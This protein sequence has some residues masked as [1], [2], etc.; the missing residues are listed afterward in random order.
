MTSLTSC[1]RC[2]TMAAHRWPGPHRRFQKYNRDHDVQRGQRAD[3]RIPRWILRRRFR[4]DERDRLA[5]MRRHFRPEFLNRLDEI[6]VFH[7]LS[8]ENL[9]RIVEI[10]LARVRAR[11]ADRHITLELTDA[12]RLQSCPHRLRSALRRPPLKRAIQKEDRNPN[13]RLLLRGQSKTA[14]AS[15]PTHPPIPAT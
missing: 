1:C 15:R 5:E 11:L 7:A 8:E 6:I 4:G 13:G 2:S 14:S 12:A 10:Q 3:S 9:K